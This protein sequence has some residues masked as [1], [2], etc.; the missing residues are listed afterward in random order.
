MLPKCQ[1]NDTPIPRFFYGTAWKEAQTA[2]FTLAALQAGFRAID[3]ANHRK[4]YHEAGTGDGI[5]AFLAT[6]ACLREDL[7]LQTK[8]TFAF[9]QEQ[10]PPYD[11]SAPM[12]EQ[13]AQSFASSLAHLH[14]D[15]IDSYVLHGPYT[16]QGIVPEDIAAWRGMEQLMAAGKVRYLGVSNVNAAQLRALCEVVSIKPQFVQNRP[17]RHSGWDAEVRA[18]CQQEGMLY[19]G[20]GL[21]LAKH[22]GQPLRPILEIAAKLQRTMPQVM[23]RFAQ[24]LGMICLNGTRNALHM[25]QD[26]E[27]ND[28]A[29]DDEQMLRILQV[30][31]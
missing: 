15:Y 9:E 11:S 14:T 4:H 17:L 21:L 12:E 18:I 3:T 10:P 5:Q 24:Q 31:Q 19:Q 7:F 22:E 2:D 16:R 25:Q 28:F 26:F 1:L 13:V 23:Y 30:A 27:I 29:L 6:G 8:F 20:F